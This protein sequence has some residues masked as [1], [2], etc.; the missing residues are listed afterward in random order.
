MP[1]LFRARACWNPRA[2]SGHS[3]L[4]VHETAQCDEGDVT[5]AALV[6][7]MQA[8]PFQEV[9]LETKRARM[10]VRGAGVP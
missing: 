6:A 3:A 5:G 1:V 9:E 7:A 2:P 8:S 4:R 10:P